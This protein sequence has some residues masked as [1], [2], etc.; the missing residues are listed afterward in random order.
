[1]RSL[2]EVSSGVIW[3]MQSGRGLLRWEGN[4]FRG[5]VAAGLDA[6]DPVLGP[7]MVD[8]SGQCWISCSKGLLLYRDP[9]AVLD[10]NLLFPLTGVTIT[11]LAEAEDGSIQAGTLEGQ[12][13]HLNQGTWS[14]NLDAA[15]PSAITDLARGPGGVLAMGTLSNG[16]YLLG[17]TNIMQLESGPASNVILSLHFDGDG[18]LWAGT[19]GGG[20]LRYANQVVMKFTSAQGL[21]DN[22]IQ[23][24]LEDEAGH[25]WMSDGAGISCIEKPVKAGERVRILSANP[26]MTTMASSQSASDAGPVARRGCVTSMRQ[27]WFATS[28]G[29]V[30]VEPPHFHNRIASPRLVLEEVLV[31]GVEAHGFRAMSARPQAG[32]AGAA[33]HQSLKLPPGKHSLDIHYTSPSFQESGPVQ[34]RYKLEGLDLHWIEAGSSRAAQYRYMPPGQYTF[35]LMALRPNGDSSQLALNLFVTPHFWQRGWVIGSAAL[36]LM[37][38]IAG[39]ARFVENRRMKRRM[40]RLEQEHALER[41]RARIAQD[42]HDEMGAKLCRISFLSEHVN[43]LEAGSPEIKPQVAAIADDSRQLLNSLDEMVWVVNPQNDTL[44]HAASYI[45]QYAINYFQGTGVECEADIA[46]GIP[47]LPVS[48]QV[49][50][51]LFLAVHEALTNALKHSAATRVRLSIAWVPPELRIRVEDNGRGFDLASGMNP[52]AAKGESHDGL[53]NMRQRMAAIGGQCIVQAAPGHG[54]QIE[55]V[56][57]VK[58]AR[59]EG[60]AS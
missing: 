15:L 25:L 12:L 36:G 21:P 60:A 9:Q 11:A 43:R 14:R 59:Q 18:V 50:H 13:W 51:H 26:L 19:A 33:T 42:L 44:E 41:E 2:T 17:Q 31:D 57:G 52:E 10:E 38:A 1:L 46:S 6:R 20:L 58:P 56:L 54:A 24:L 16:V 35:N 4:A 8:A 22:N 34:F 39:G 27:L 28:R 3:G 23:S 55:F 29:A 47:H 53:T 5:I 30:V 7:M 40:L 48:S 32:D 37:F 45:G 49:R